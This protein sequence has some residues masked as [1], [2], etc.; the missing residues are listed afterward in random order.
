MRISVNRQ[1]HWLAGGECSIK[2]GVV[3]ITWGNS[4]CQVP[5]GASTMLGR[6]FPIVFTSNLPYHSL[7]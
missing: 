6:L 7:T 2:G 1:V 5:G 4:P 3:V